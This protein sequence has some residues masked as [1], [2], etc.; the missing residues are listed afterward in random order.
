MSKS[1][2]KLAWGDRV[3]SIIARMAAA[4]LAAVLFFPLDHDT[5]NRKEQPHHHHA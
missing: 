2:G 4:L 5:K 1:P 3:K